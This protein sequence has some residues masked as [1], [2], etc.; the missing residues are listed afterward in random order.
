MIKVDYQVHATGW[1]IQK[2]LREL[3]HQ[4][5]LAFD[6]E[7]SGVYAKEERAKAKAWLEKE[8]KFDD[9]RLVSLIAN[10]SGLSYPSLINVTHFV[11][12]TSRS[13]AVILVP[14]N[15]PQEMFVWQFLRSYAGKVIVHNSLFDLKIMYH[16]VKELPSDFD[17]TALMAKAMINNADNWKAKIGLKDIMAEHYDPRWEMIDEYEPDDPLE[18]KF[19]RYASIDGAATFYLYELLLEMGYEETV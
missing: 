15:P 3:A 10:N 17:D 9:R 7:T 16:R 14:E 12:G 1:H 18:Q 6:T 11:F 19:L 5:I 13:T 8:I 4:P 2:A